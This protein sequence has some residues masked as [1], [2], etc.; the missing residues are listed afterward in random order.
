MT[1]RMPDPTALT[2]V[3][4]LGLSYPYVQLMTLVACVRRYRK[5]GDAEAASKS[6]DLSIEFVPEQAVATY[7]GHN[8]QVGLPLKR[9]PLE[10][11]RQ[12]ESALHEIV[13]AYPAW[14]GALSL[15]I[16]FCIL[17]R[18]G[19]ISASADALPQHIFLSA[20]AFETATQL[21]EQVLHELSHQWLYLLAEVSPLDAKPSFSSFS[22]PSG[23][24]NRKASEVLGAA[25]VAINLLTVNQRSPDL[26]EFPTRR[27]DELKSY[28]RD[29]FSTL[30]QSSDHLTATGE[31]AFDSLC[32]ASRK[33]GN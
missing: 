18:A 31:M 28:L 9:L 17:D 7:S 11:N 10:M 5:T 15:P 27:V 19:A 13:D 30:E 1:K 4:L 32:R 2:S 25:H 16:R 3:P 21:R 29:C 22:L 14:I 24:S 8:N 20:E 33:F 23:T 26:L 6:K 12:A